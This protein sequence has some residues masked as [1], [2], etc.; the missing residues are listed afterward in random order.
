MI[1]GIRRPGELC[2]LQ[3]L[4]PLQQTG[5]LPPLLRD[6]QLRRPIQRRGLLARRHNSLTARSEYDQVGCRG[7][8]VQLGEGSGVELL[9]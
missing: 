4:Q 3:R 7:Y 6:N 1:S 8:M 2:R 5:I 9:G